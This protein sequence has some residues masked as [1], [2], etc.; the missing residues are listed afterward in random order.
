[1]S[2]Y[3]LRFR[4]TLPYIH[5]GQPP[6]SWAEAQ[7]ARARGE[8]QKTQAACTAARKKDDALVADNP[9]NEP[10]TRKSPDMMPAWPKASRDPRC[11]S[12]SRD[13]ADSQGLA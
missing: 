6:Q 4:Q 12:R 2:A 10:T 11:T 9:D 5:D 13:P 3:A 8:K 7:V 1:M